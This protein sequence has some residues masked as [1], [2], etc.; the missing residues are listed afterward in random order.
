M[1]ESRYREAETRMWN[2]VGV[3]PTEQRLRLS[4]TGLTLRVQEV[5][6]GPA[7]VFVHGASNSGVS[8]AQLVAG[9]DGFRC[10]LLDRPGCGLSEP[11]AGGFDDVSRLGEF[12]DNLIVDVLDALGLESAH[13]V[14]TSF[15]GF[16][17]LHTAA[18]HPDRVDRLVELGWTIGAPIASTPFV[19]R[20]ASVR[21]LG[22]MMASIPPNERAVRSILKAAGLREALAAGRV[23]QEMVETFMALLRDTDTMRNELKAGPRIMTP[24]RG[25]NDSILL[26]ASLLASI[27]TPTYFLWG[28]GDPFGGADIA[29]PFVAQIPT[30][31]L[32]LMP[33]GHA[34]WIDD[35]EYAAKVVRSFLA[36]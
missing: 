8:W 12:A 14:S 28:E 1:N 22:R 24:L 31:E 10:I 7:I 27:K 29:R 20:L 3:T 26:P 4:R 18:A 32:E 6:E 25:I 19:M 36:G 9:L 15:G 16:I 23:S 2:S 17:A 13:V 34:V 30:A 35:P 21:F 11:V 5:G 33:G